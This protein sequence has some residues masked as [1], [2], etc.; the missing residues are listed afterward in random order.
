MSSIIKENQYFDN[1]CDFCKV[2]TCDMLDRV[3]RALLEARISFSIREED[4]SLFERIF[5]NR[6]NKY[7][8]IVRINSLDYER[9]VRAVSDIRGVSIICEE[10]GRDWCPM[11]KVRRRQQEAKERHEEEYYYYAEAVPLS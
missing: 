11:D 2:Y 10:P 8:S 7:R 3:E 6:K 4:T 1:G 5:G 9:A